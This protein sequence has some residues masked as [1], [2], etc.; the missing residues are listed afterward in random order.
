MTTKDSKVDVVVVGAGFAGIYGVYRFREEGYS[1]LCIEEAPDV[2]GVWYH[3]AYPGARCDVESIDYSYSFS[4]DLQREWEWA[5]R[6]ASQPEILRYLRHVAERFNLRARIR[7]N[8]RVIAARRNPDDTLWLVETDTGDQIVCRYLVMASGSLSAR[9]D[10]DFEGLADFKGEWYQTSR[11]PKEPIHFAGKRVGTIGTG[12]SGIQCIPKIAETANHLT[13]FQRTATFSIPARNAPLDK[14]A[15]VAL[16]SRYAEYRKESLNHRIGSP[17]RTTGKPTTAFSR[18]E[19]QEILLREWE[20]GGPS[21]LNTFT[22]GGRVK[23]ANDEIAEFVRE[24]IC[25]IV[26]DP[27]TAELLCPKDH[28]IGSR[29]IC[30]DTD[31][32]ATYNR[33][34]VALI[35]VRS[36]PIERVTPEGLKTQSGKR[37]LLD[38]LVFAIGFDAA[39]GALTRIDIRNAQGTSIAEKWK[40][41]AP[42]YLGLMTAGFPNLFMVTGPGSPSVLVNMVVAIEHDIRW[43]AKLINH[44]RMKD[45]RRV[46]AQATAEAEWTAYVAELGSGLLLTTANSYYMNSNIPGKARYLIAYPYG[47]PPYR[48]HVEKIVAEGYLGFTLK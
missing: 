47:W 1:V 5:E 32:Y 7:F 31:Y 26:K 38:V 42:T 33:P 30:I 48:A 23:Q 3:N 12:S 21:L 35:D 28:P 6:Y 45:F 44:M 16:K 8:T 24:R 4:D 11:W 36:D 19:R 37:Y 17:L 25:H 27:T 39:T 10:P 43:I 13:V 46:E 14:T 29:R 34:N 9:K 22:D 2:G 41:G 20:Q 18:Q 15:F 40:Y